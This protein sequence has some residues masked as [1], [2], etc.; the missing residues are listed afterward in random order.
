MAKRAES[1]V[2]RVA[3]KGYWREAEA[4]VILAAL[5][6]SGEGLAAFARRH[7]V[8]PR[9]LGR[10]RSRLGEG[11][12]ASVR[13]HPVQLSSVAQPRVPESSGIEI[14]LAG[15]RRVRVG[16]GFDAEDLRRVVAVLEGGS[17]C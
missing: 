17:A 4:R 8:D 2:R 16:H 11:K 7:E 13:F 10:W 5:A 1:A 6:E 9:R 14:E 3:K 15:G 12:E